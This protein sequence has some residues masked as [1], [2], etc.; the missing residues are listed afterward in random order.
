MAGEFSVRNTSAGEVSPSSTSMW[1]IEESCP[2][3][4]WVSMPV[5]SVNAAAHASVTLRCWEE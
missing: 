5:S 3:R 2:S 1:P 4:T